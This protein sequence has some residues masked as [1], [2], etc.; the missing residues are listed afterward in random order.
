MI[1]HNFTGVQKL[2]MFNS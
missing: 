1:S 2:Q